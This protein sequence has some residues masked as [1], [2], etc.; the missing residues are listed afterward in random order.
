MKNSSFRVCASTSSSF[1]RICHCVAMGQSPCSC[2][3]GP[4]VNTQTITGDDSGSV[5]AVRDEM[6]NATYEGSWLD[7]QKHGHGVL[8]GKDGAKY[9]GQFKNDKKEGQGTY[10]YPSGA[11][12]TG[13]WLNDLQE[14]H[15]KEEWADGSIFEGEFKAGAKHG[16][17][18]FIWSTLCRYEGEFDNNDMCLGSA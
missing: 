15:G 11:K 13:E 4:S 14:G 8:V 9:V 5:A 6:G 18:Q 17:G 16:R 10:Y 3:R 2:D 12:Y 7:G 1:H